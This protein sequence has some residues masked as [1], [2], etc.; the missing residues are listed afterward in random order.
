MPRDLAYLLD[1]L[2]ALDFGQSPCLNDIVD[3]IAT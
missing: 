2:Q 3:K 1:I